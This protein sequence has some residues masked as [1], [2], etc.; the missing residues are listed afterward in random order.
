MR[1]RLVLAL[2]VAAVLGC[3]LL[4]GYTTAPDGWYAALVKP[5]FNPPAWVFAPAWTVLYLMIAVAGWQVWR[6]NFTRLQQLWWLSLGLNFLWSP[7]F[8]GLQHIGAALLVIALMDLAVL[9]FMWLAW[10][11]D[12]AAFWLFVPYAGWLCYATLLNSAIFM[13]N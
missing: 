12:K 3:G 1:D 7:V 11:R 10:P 6:R 8:F 2:F 13:L 9:A 4:I 5:G